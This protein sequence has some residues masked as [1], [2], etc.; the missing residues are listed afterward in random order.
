MT[1]MHPAFVRILIFIYVA[2][3]SAWP[4]SAETLITLITDEEARL[5]D[6]EMIITRGPIPGPQIRVLSPRTDLATKSPLHLKLTF[7]SFAGSNI[8]VDSI[9]ITYMK[10]PLV[11]LTERLKPFTSQREIDMIGAEAPPGNHQIRVQV[12]DS[13]GR[14]G[15]EYL[16]LKVAR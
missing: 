2:F 14:I 7:R 1:Q 5:P 6:A 8:D 4:A 9:R 15:V 3:F 12:Q 10:T 16:A 13:V 11:D